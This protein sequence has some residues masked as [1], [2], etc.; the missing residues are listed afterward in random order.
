RCSR[1]RP[2]RVRRRFAE[3]RADVRLLPERGRRGE[4]RRFHRAHRRD[5][6][7]DHAFARGSGICRTG[8]EAARRAPTF[9][10]GGEPMKL[11]YS[12]GACSRAVRIALHEAGIAFD[13]VL[14]S[15]K[16]HQLPDGTDYYSV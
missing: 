1:A 5:A 12:P 2:L 7:L 14:A 16:T 8:A 10:A 3:R 4:R 6:P 13:G 9:P 15:T 11:Y